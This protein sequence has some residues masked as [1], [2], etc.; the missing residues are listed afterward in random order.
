MIDLSIILTI[1]E[2]KS[3]NFDKYLLSVYS[4]FHIKS[5]KL[6]LFINY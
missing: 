5:L 2:E 6:Y 4:L 1:I 3:L